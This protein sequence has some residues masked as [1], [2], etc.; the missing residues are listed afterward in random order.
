MTSTAPGTS[1]LLTRASR[2]SFS[3]IGASTNPATPTGTLTKKIHSQ[4]SASVSTPP[5]STP[6]TAP[7]APTAPQA[8]SAVF[9][10]LPSAN[11]VLRIESAAGVIIAAPR[12]CSERATI[13]DGL[14]P[15]EPG[16]ERGA[17]EDDQPD[18]EHA[19]AADDVGDPPAEQ[20][21]AAEEERVG[22]HDPLQVLL[23]EPEVGLDGRQG[24]VHDRDVE[25][26]HELHR[27]G[28]VRVRTTSVEPMRSWSSLPSHLVEEACQS[29]ARTCKE[30]QSSTS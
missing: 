24:D 23:R 22:A 16:Q 17:G 14:A 2:L 5:S 19:P 27:R 1:K 8:P 15:G 9:R 29:T 30:V 11:V 4:L 20:Q 7:N 25:H 10:S 12:P 21:E 13:S 3:R 26:D 18:D 28:A 6:A